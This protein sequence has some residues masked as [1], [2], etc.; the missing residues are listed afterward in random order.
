MT[1]LTFAHDEDEDGWC[2]FCKDG[3]PRGVRIRLAE[4]TGGVPQVGP[5]FD[6][7]GDRETLNGREFFY[8][9]G[10]CCIGKMVN[11]LEKK[12]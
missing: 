5:T 9:I 8:R 3:S 6:R 10:A 7:E 1:L 12:T 11:A 2:S 4:V